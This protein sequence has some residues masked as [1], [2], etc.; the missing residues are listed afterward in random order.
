MKYKIFL[1]R[2]MLLGIIA[3]VLTGVCACDSTNPE[4]ITEPGMLPGIDQNERGDVSFTIDVPHGAGEGTC[5]SPVVVNSGDTLRMAINQKSSYRD[6][7]G[8]VFTC[9]PKSAIKLYMTM[10]TVYA[11]DLDELRQVKEPEVTTAS[12]GSY[13]VSHRTVQ[14]FDVGGQQI[15]F[16]LMH[17]VYTYC[18]STGD[19]IEMPHVKLRE[20]TLGGNSAADSRSAAVMTGVSVRPLAD[21]GAEH[22][23]PTIFEVNAKFS[24]DLEKSKKLKND[25]AR[26]LEISVNYIGVVE[27]LTR[28]NNPKSFLLYKWEPKS[29]TSSIAPPFVKTKGEAMEVW[30]AQTST[31][32]DEYANRAVSQPK[33]TIKLSIAEDTVWGKD[34]N[35]LKILAEQTEGTADGQSTIQRFGSELQTVDIDWSYEGG[36]ADLGGHMIAMPHYSLSPVS[37][38]DVSVKELCDTTIGDKMATLYEVTATFRQKAVAENMIDRTPDIDIEYVASYIGAIEIYLVDVEYI[39]SG[40]WVDPH[41]NMALAY[42]AK[43]ERYRTYSNGKRVGPDEFYDYGH[44]SAPCCGYGFVEGYHDWYG[45]WVNGYPYTHTIIGDS[46]AI[47]TQK[48][49]LSQLGTFEYVLEQDEWYSWPH[50]NNAEK[51]VFPNWSAPYWASKLYGPEVDVAKGIDNSSYPEDSRPSGWYF[52]E[53]QRNKDYSIYWVTPKGGHCGSGTLTIDFTI[54]D[55]FLVIDGRRIDFSP[56]H[57]IKTD[58]SLTETDF[59]EAD[60][61]GKISKLE[62]NASYLG[63]NFYAAQ[64]DTFYVAK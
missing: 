56:L 31:Y 27:T 25:S 57:N 51:D 16:D 44:L 36:E 2:N 37:V 17:E 41:D 11:K 19:K 10:D 30:L 54:N 38:K 35:E 33:A 61:K 28:P 26:T 64:I 24:L 20:A 22:S 43:V 45:E 15:V 4:F 7:D 52:Y 9:E 21:R 62:M 3:I 12:S 8:S 14:T 53:Y 47:V 6:P 46:I 34:V 13:P 63:K 5:S 32:T 49:E 60:K 40:E 50:G 18:A 1:W 59:E 42:Y 39:P 23:G 58:Y 55:Q 48:I 29:G